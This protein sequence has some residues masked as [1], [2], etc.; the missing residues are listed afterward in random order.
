MRTSTT[1]NE[2]LQGIVA[3]YRASGEQWP[4]PVSV[5]AAWANEHGLFERH[6]E[7]L[8]RI[9]AEMIRRAMREEYVR[10]PQ[11]RTVR[12]KHSARMKIDG[13]QLCLWDDIR[14]ASRGFMQ[15]AF[16]NRRRGIVADCHQLKTDIDSFNENYNRGEPIPLV[17]DFGPDIAEIEVMGAPPSLDEEDDED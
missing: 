13:K 7:A 2:Y 3:S 11:G 10:D 16:Q 9:Y 1:Q 12:A 17:L 4:A 8:V 14:T 15:V 6:P 5:I